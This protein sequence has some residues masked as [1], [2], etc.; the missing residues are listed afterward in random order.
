MSNS[1]GI[2]GYDYIEFYTGSAKMTA[3]WLV[4]A[5]GMR[6]SGY[7]GPECG[8]KDR[9]SHYLTQNQ[10]KIVV[11]SP[12]TPDNFEVASFVTAHGDGVKRWAMQVDHVAA[13]FDS[14]LAGGAVPIRY[15]AKTD[16]EKGFVEEAAIRL[17]DDAELVFINDDHYRGIFKPGFVE[18]RH[19]MAG[20]GEDPRLLSVDHI[21]GNARVNE[22]NQWV[23][24]LN[25]SLDF[26]TSIHFGPGDITTRYSSLLSTVVKSKDNR[27]KI[28]IN[29]PYEGLK[30]SQ[31]EEYIN[32][33]HGTGIQH[34]ALT[35]HDILATIGALR[36]NGVSFLDIPDNYYDTLTEK[37]AKLTGSQ[38]ITEDLERIRRLGILC[39][40]ESTGYLLQL[41]TQPVSDRPTFF[42]EIIQRRNG[43][44]GFGQGNFQALF[45][46]IEREQAERG[47]LDR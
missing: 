14:A 5:L 31:I 33:Y 8:I 47:N 22:M 28:P 18:P 30:V 24:Y 46:S 27:I 23:N 20:R 12:L 4:N 44:E 38:K 1:L 6:H 13:A 16:D 25:Q 34:I 41:F 43:S 36:A 10:I 26:E 32:E 37:N 35:T 40:P 45:E 3:F 11:T 29:E 9:I 42:F 2:R 15:P 19:R 7:S 17:Y 21:V 39:D